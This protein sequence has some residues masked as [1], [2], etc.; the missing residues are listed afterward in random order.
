MSNAT[1][2]DASRRR[3]FWLLPPEAYVDRPT[4]AAVRY[5]SVH[6]LEAEAINGGGPPYKRIGRRAMY[7]KADFLAWFD[8]TGRTVENTAQLSA[9]SA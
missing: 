5:V 9:E 4:A 2:A 3:E 1:D 7:R 6:T 8:R